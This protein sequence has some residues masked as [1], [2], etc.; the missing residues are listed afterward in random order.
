MPTIRI[1]TKRNVFQ[2]RNAGP[3]GIPGPQGEP[4]AGAVSSVNGKAGIVTLDTDDIPGGSSNLY[5]TE[6]KVNAN[7]NVAA[8]TAAR[9]AHGNLAILDSTT[10]PFTTAQ[11]TKLTGVEGGAQVNTVESVNGQTGLIS[12]DADDINDSLAAHKFVTSGDLVKLGNLSGNNSGDQDLTG[13]FNVTT[14]TLDDIITGVINKQFTDTQETKLAGIETLADVTD[15]QNVAT[16]GAV[17]EIDTS[18]ALMNFVVDEDNMVSNSATKI[19]TQ[20]SVKAY[21]DSIAQ[22]LDDDLTTIAS[23]SP[24]NDD[25]LQRKAG[26]WT[27]RGPSQVKT[28]LAL[29]KSDVGLANID[30]TSDVNK[31]VSTAVQTALDFKQ[32]LDDD[33][34][35][36]AGL[37]VVND[38]IIQRKAGSWVNRT[39]AQL[40]TDLVLT[41]TDVGLG[42]VPNTDA[43]LRANHT[44]TQTASTISDFSSSVDSII[45]STLGVTVQ[46]YD[47][48]L[49]AIAVLVASND[50]IIQRKSGVWTNRTTS[51]LKTD[52]ALTNTD[53]GL[54]DVPNIDATVRANHTGTQVAS[55][56]SDFNTQ[57]RTS[58]LDQMAVPTANLDINSNK[59][60]GV[61]DPSSDQDVATKAYVDAIAQGL[62]IKASVRAATTTA[63]TL[64]TSFENGDTIDGVT[65]ATNDRILV[66]N[67]VAGSENGLYLVNASGAPTRTMDANSGAELVAGI[68]TFVNEGTINANSGWVQTTIGTITVDTTAL[69][70][71]QFSGAG[72]IM[73]GT[74]MTKTGNTLDVGAG[75]GITVASDSVSVD[76][77]VYR[78]GS[79]DVA[80]ADGGTGSSTASDARTALGLAIGTDVQAF[81]SDL[82]TIASLTATTDNFIVSVASA[83]ASRTPAQ[84]RT[85]LTLNNVDNTSDANKPVST[86][87]Q[88]ALNAKVTGPS[89][90]TDNAVTRYDG[91][92]GKLIQNSGAILD[93]NANLTLIDPS[94]PVLDESPARGGLKFSHTNGVGTSVY[95][96][97]QTSYDVLEIN[98]IGDTT[99]DSPSHVLVDLKSPNSSAGGD[100]ESTLAL[101]T[102]AGAPGNI[103]RTLDI[104]N[105]DYSRDHGVGFRQLIKNTTANPMRWEI[106]DKT[107]SSGA[108]VLGEIYG[109]SGQFTF[110]SI[111][112]EQTGITPSVDDWVWDNAGAIFADD[113]KIIAVQLN[114]PSAGITTYTINRA[115]TAS[116]NP[117]TARGKSIKE[118]MRLTPARQL[119]VRKY[120]AASGSNVAEFG[121]SVAIDGALTLGTALAVAQ[122][123]TGSSTAS[124]ARTS[125]GLEI[126]TNVQA[127]DSDLSAV[128]GL[129]STGIVSRT[130]SGTAAVRSIAV[131][132]TKLTISNADGVSGNPTLDAAD[133]TSSQ[134][135]AIQLANDLGGSATA[136]EVKSRTVTATIGKTVG[137]F[138]VSNYTDTGSKTAFQQALEAA[139]AVADKVVIRNSATPY[140]LKT[141]HSMISGK[142]LEGESKAGVILQM[143]T[144]TNLT[145]I[146]N[147]DASTGITTN[148]T[149]KNIT[150]DQQGSSQSGG[151]GI[152]VTG[153]QGW[154]IENVIIKTSYSFNFL[155]LHQG[156][157]LTNKT[158]T[159]TFTNGSE[160]VTGSGTAFT[161]ELAVGDIVKS[162]GA[163]FV[164]VRSITSNTEFISTIPWGYTTESAVTFK[165][166]QPNSN[167][168]LKRLEY[169]GTLNNV[170]AS[171]YGFFDNSIIEDCIGHN[172]TGAGCGF[173]PDHARGTRLIN[174]F[175][176]SNANSGYSFETCED[177]VV[178]GGRSWLNGNG[179]QLISGSVR[180][181]AIGLECHDNVSHGF[182]ISYNITGAPVSDENT[183]DNISSHDNGG[184]GVRIDGSHRNKVSGR[185]FNNNTGGVILNVANSRIP[186]L[187]T[188]ENLK[189]Y[190]NRTTKRQLRG[191]WVV[192]ADQTKI[193]NCDSRDA[194]HVTAGFTD[195]GTNTSIITQYAGGVGVNNNN[196]ANKLT[197]NTPTTADS[198]AQMIVTSPSATTKPLVLQANASQ[199]GNMI[200]VQSSAGNN[201]FNMTS[202]GLLRGPAASASAPTFSYALDGSTG[203]YRPSGVASTVRIATAANDRFQIN[204]TST[205]FMHGMIFKR[206]ALTV[207]YSILADDYML[208][209]TA[210]AAPR[211]ATLPT[212]A[213]VTG[214]VYIIKDESGN[215]TTNN[216]T[217]ATTSSQTI[218]ATSTYVINVNYGWVAV[219]SNGS[220]WNVVTSSAIVGLDSDLVALAGIST[221]GLLAH[222]GSGTAAART[223][224]AGS[225]KLT[226][227]NG[228]GVSGNP[229]VDL[230]SVASTD[231][232]D[233]SSIYKS[234]GTDV[235]VVDGGT[236]SSTASG[237]RT[238]L[239]VVIGSDVQAHDSDLDAVAALSPSDDDILQRKSG[240]WTNRTLAQMKADIP[241]SDITPGVSELATIAE[242]N[243]GTDTGRAVTPDGLAGSVH[244]TKSISMQVFDAGT[245]VA[246]GD[247][248]LYLRVPSSLNGM[249][250]I[251]VSAGVFAKSTSGTPTVQIARGRQANATSAHSFVDVLSTLIT[252]DANEFDSKDATTAAVI[253]ASNDDLATGDLFRID[254]DVAGT[255]T[256]GLFITIECRLP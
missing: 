10:A 184:Y 57:V 221:N 231:L 176:Y 9:H 6:A 156:S 161:T 235:A 68:F 13:Y 192:S 30:N 135:G 12:L 178:I 216:L 119:L 82:S 44:G 47:A 140:T 133:A 194:D 238:N 253:N 199:S 243:T 54:S 256:L 191:I 55:T 70:F 85:T 242:T 255:G 122:G 27:N 115:L 17:M 222:T 173:V 143:N 236:G 69:V 251:G 240:A 3:R 175:A 195:T 213:S 230:G 244:G 98:R 182:S 73:A 149:I 111:V 131:G 16:A 19:P 51:Q 219:Y 1:I 97:A 207:N 105:D 218:D 24:A 41:K 71:T 43:T 252:I 96:F 58:R 229:T 33:L 197:I 162:A 34:T 147:A 202:G 170:D 179:Y 99:A 84:V 72:Q 94:A 181:S 204:N 25:L 45:S 100:S 86:A 125:L 8:N 90:A 227:T 254:V 248:K 225:A 7:P 160:V 250:V 28:D 117:G 118:I 241:A 29:T 154:H 63:G 66:K 177:I 106:H 146:T 103:S 163:Q 5:Y 215:A 203:M 212:A 208:A 130:G 107:T 23:L 153:I 247:G 93:D 200:E 198:L 186:F 188:L 201:F 74:G 26:A 42:S 223:L 52:L 138:P 2:I 14:Q 150:V 32:N 174:C 49:A 136:P 108:F 101:T 80:V 232:S 210:L 102:Y 145:V 134:K 180:C 155:A 78:Q 62:S 75:T 40:K 209:Y 114:T 124:G 109:I 183:L 56:I 21:V 89:S 50:D 224:A 65:L 126:G 110:T 104:Y 185:V 249:N 142:T 245:T 164:R 206:T 128:A 60:V 148:V 11:Q 22:S 18:T 166:I 237:A 172:A 35:A 88:T 234:G 190:D 79:T 20:Q 233:S 4:G 87:T 168:Y 193:I 121:G 246:T 217:I 214:Q 165:V 220:N 39:P 120:I 205:T 64:A 36:I 152:V 123:G 113:T 76:N 137:D 239:G 112:S 167:H 157:G 61:A 127:F 129:S 91:T 132:S 37:T 46:A 15:A 187:N 228:D 141:T 196:P 67:Q 189:I 211:T 48:D 226:I 92:T 139:F 171:G 116:P 158:G 144:G 95:T 151:G 31:P 59:L 77:T 159:A 83:W 53:V 169:Q 81:D 38:D